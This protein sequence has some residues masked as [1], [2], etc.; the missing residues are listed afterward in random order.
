[1]SS[2]LDLLLSHPRRASDQPTVQ[3]LEVSGDALK[4]REGKLK[5]IYKVESLGFF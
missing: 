1:V 3:S 2:L 5:Y 4:G